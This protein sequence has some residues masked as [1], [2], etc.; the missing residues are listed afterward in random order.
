M[1]TSGEGGGGLRFQIILPL[2]SHF[3]NLK[4]LN[5]PAGRVQWSGNGEPTWR[6]TVSP[7]G[8]ER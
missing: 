6:R 5:L 3:S 7:H 1:H 2:K 4:I 8:G